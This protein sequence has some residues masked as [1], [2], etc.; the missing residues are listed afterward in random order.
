MIIL[1]TNLVSEP[2]KPQPNEAV[3]AWLD[4][5]IPE[6]LYLTRTSLCELLEGVSKLPEGKRK[7]SFRSDLLA[8][9]QLLFGERIL[10]FDYDAALN[11]AAL[12][13]KAL[14]TGVSISMGD[15]QIATIAMS[16]KYAVA[17]RDDGPFIAAG[18]RVINP[19]QL[20]N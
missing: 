12:K 8:L 17:T 6:T 16:K 20:A 18:V 10:P 15:E 3:L 2:L 4:R 5:Q 11:C 7:E 13:A 14:Q 9:I 19:W 1:D